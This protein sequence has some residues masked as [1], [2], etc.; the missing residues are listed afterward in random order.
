MAAIHARAFRAQRPWSAAE[1]A[2]LLEQA[3][4]DV[5][6]DGAGFILLRLL[7]PEVEILTLAVDPA[8]QRKGRARALVG[9]AMARAAGR[10]ATR[11]ILEVASRNLAARSL[12]SGLGFR[13]IGHRR[14]YY[15][16][17]G[18]GRDDAI[19]ME[20][21]LLAGNAGNTRRG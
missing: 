8:A 13:E 1:F 11:A 5:L 9:A 7:P 16:V 18:G 14:A 10:G 3:G 6:G 20:L 21:D 4:T 19:V 15:V 2:A 17:P 12:Y